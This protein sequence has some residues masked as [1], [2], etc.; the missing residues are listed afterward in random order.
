[1]RH[2]CGNA[3]DR[4]VGLRDD[5]EFDTAVG[6]VPQNE[7]GFAATRMKLRAVCRL[8][9]QHA[10]K[11]NRHGRCFAGLLKCQEFEEFIH[12][13]EATG[14]DGERIGTH[15]QV[16]LAHRE[17]VETEGEFG[18]GIGIGFL[19]V[20]QRDVEPDAWR[21]CIRG[22]PVGRL[23]DAGPAAGRDNIVAQAI[24]AH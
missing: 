17:I 4:A 5:D 3:G 1:M 7:D 18:R 20:R 19:L 15:G 16:H 14:K 6:I 21:A 8:F 11:D 24:V 13:A 22:A 2:P 23:H 12:S 9:E 10:Q